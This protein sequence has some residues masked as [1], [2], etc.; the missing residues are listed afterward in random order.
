MFSFQKTI[1]CDLDYEKL[2]KIR[3]NTGFKQNEIIAYRKRF[4]SYITSP[5]VDYHANRTMKKSNS[6]KLLDMLPDGGDSPRKGKKK[7]LEK[8]KE[9]EKDDNEDEVKSTSDEQSHSSTLS[10][11]LL[12]ADKAQARPATPTTTP[13]EEPVD[14]NTITRTQFLNIQLIAMN[15]LRDRLALLFDLNSVD[16]FLTFEEYMDKVCQ[17]NCIGNREAKLKLAFKIQDFDGD[18]K[19]DRH[20]LSKY[21]GLIARLGS[22]ET[23]VA[24][25]DR[26]QIIQYILSEASSDP[27]QKYLSFED[28]QRVVAPTDFDSMLRLKL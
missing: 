10:E 28:F 5:I 17:F 19:L 9:K 22:V 23:K 16:S 25:D 26:R 1:P 21:Y 7:E 6:S 20:D 12:E 3:M 24:K 13:A 4:L 2:E 14:L 15:P 18:E 27:R 8:E 11:E